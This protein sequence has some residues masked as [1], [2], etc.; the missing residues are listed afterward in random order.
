MSVQELQSLGQQPF[1]AELYKK[2][3]MLVV[4]EQRWESRIVEA[5]FSPIHQT[6]VVKS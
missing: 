2:D 3:P 1:C 5:Q 6:S 4:V